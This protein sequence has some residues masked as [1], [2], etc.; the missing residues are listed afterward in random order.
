MYTKKITSIVAISIVMLTASCKKD[1]GVTPNSNNSAA[2]G[3][4]LIF[5]FK[6]DS[7]Q[8]R[9]NSFGQPTALA[10]GHAAQCPKFNSISAHYIELAPSQYTAVGSGKVL[11]K[12]ADTTLGGSKAI[13]FGK[14]KVVA[15]GE[16][17][18]KIP[19]SSINPGTYQYLRVSLAYQNYEIKCRTSGIDLTG[20]VAS[21]IGYNTYIKDYKIKT[22]TISPNSNKA[23]GYWGFEDNLIHSIT[24]GQAPAG[25]TTVPNPINSTSPIPAGSCLVT[26]GFTTPFTITG[27]ET[28]DVVITMSLSTNK[29]FEWTDNGD[30]IYEPSAGDVVVDMGV[31]GLQPIV[32]P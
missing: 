17:F 20:T 31:R 15:E 10:S 22:Q 21:F 8:Q 3:P 19:L 16:Q 26:G 30:G 27:A 9:L 25:L 2:S 29:S 12:A 23:Q 11:Y 6:F 24:T 13:D 28:A 5:K 18:L 7:T 32:T 1:N 14:A 4:S